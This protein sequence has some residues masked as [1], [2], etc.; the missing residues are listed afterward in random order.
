VRRYGG[1]SVDPSTGTRPT[2]PVLVV[3][4]VLVFAVTMS[5]HGFSSV[6]NAGGD[7]Y[8]TV[9]TSRAIAL[10]QTLDLRS[11]YS[12]LIRG[13]SPNLYRRTVDGRERVYDYFPYG[14]AVMTLPL[15]PV[16]D[17]VL[18]LQGSNLDRYLH[19]NPIP[20]TLERVLASFFTGLAA[21]TM[22]VLGVLRLGRRHW[23]AALA[24]A[25]TLAFATSAWSVAS[26]ALWMQGPS[27]LVLT[28]ALA[29]VVRAE[30]DP[31]WVA[32]L[33][34][35]VAW[36][37]VVRPTNVVS[38]V[39]LSALVAVRW[40]EMLL[41]YLLGAAVVAVPFVAVNLGTYGEVLPPY[42]RGDRL[43]RD[44]D[45]GEALVGNLVSPARGL[46]VY[47]PFVVVLAVW[48]FVIRRRDRGLYSVEV[49]AV[50]AVVLHWLVIS[51]YF[52]W[53]AGWTYGPRFFI[54]VLPYLFLLALPAFARLF[55][56][57][58]RIRHEGSRRRAFAAI[59]LVLAGW[60]LFVQWRGATRFESL[61]WNWEP[62]NVDF[63]P[64]RL[65]SWSDPPF[66]R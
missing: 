38:V 7:S 19:E 15:M 44:A 16:A 6:S 40:R 30:R 1:R 36:S 24:A 8:W 64:E 62:E 43:F 22:F 32:L 59:T 46:L 51:S 12:D 14:V 18:H 47:S 3:V 50:V 11:E 34:P 23:P 9:F 2:T 28:V 29:I 26:R 20:G 31:R 60:S 10:R 57:L 37:Y 42:Y 61:Q 33:G 66:L 39:V 5:V 45:L 56:Y 27:M 63:N 13:D 25:V 35:V 41:R 52:H 58:R 48:G 53:W 65:W 21:V 54:D 55:G 49:A 17:A 4:G